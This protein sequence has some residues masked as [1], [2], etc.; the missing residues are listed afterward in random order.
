MEGG[1]RGGER[2]RESARTRGRETE[3]EREGDRNTEGGGGEGGREINPEQY[4][5]SALN[6]EPLP[7]SN[8]R[9]PS[10]ACIQEYH[11]QKAP[12]RA[13]ARV[14]E[15]LGLRFGVW[16]L[17]LGVV[18]KGVWEWWR[19]SGA[20]SCAEGVDQEKTGGDGERS[21][22]RSRPISCRTVHARTQTHTQERVGVCSCVWSVCVCGWVGVWVGGWVWVGVCVRA[23]TH[24]CVRMWVGVP[25][26]L[27]L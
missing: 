12:T 1:E 18:R 14:R 22:S 6:S 11:M 9:A 25:P 17:G 19:P 27:A 3:R 23:H 4:P 7:T 8:P 13:C 21:P 20:E 24:V 10:R 2:E 15:V 16:W 26:L 5:S